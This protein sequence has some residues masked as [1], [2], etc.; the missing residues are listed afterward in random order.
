VALLR[1]LIVPGALLAVLPLIAGHNGIYIAVPVAEFLTFIVAVF[2]LR[3]INK[4][5]RI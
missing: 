3:R 5:L 1:S 2:L 4:D